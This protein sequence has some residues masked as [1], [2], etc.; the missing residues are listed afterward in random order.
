MRKWM[1]GLFLLG[2]TLSAQI[3]TVVFDWGHVLAKV[4]REEVLGGLERD[5]GISAETLKKHQADFAQVQ[6]GALTDEDFLE[7]CAQSVGVP[8]HPEWKPKLKAIYRQA[9]DPIPGM[10]EL[11]EEL[12]EKGYSLALLSN[13]SPLASEVARELGHYAPFEPVLLSWEMGKL[14]PDPLIYT[15]MLE[16]LQVEPC[17]CIFIDDRLEN[18]QAA[19]A[20]GIRAIHFT[21]FEGAKRAIYLMLSE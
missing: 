4:D 17:E 8:L 2:G 18:V 3:T 12:Q 13:V 21:G 11:A 6:I 9:F 19:E 16:E 5:L 7:R 14:K 10:F 1:L 15:H 20:L